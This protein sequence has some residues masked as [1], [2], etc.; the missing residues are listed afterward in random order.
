MKS[1]NLLI[2]QPSAWLVLS[3][4]KQVKYR[5]TFKIGLGLITFSHRKIKTDKPFVQ[6]GTVHQQ[7]HRILN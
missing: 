6:G 1:V 4:D 5:V 7:S 2:H 3:V